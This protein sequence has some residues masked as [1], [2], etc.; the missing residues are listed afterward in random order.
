MGLIES[1]TT[2][3]FVAFFS[4]R[5][6]GGY[7]RSEAPSGLERLSQ[8]WH[9]IGMADSPAQPDDLD[10]RDIRDGLRERIRL[11]QSIVDDAQAKYE[12]EKA[13]R[14]IEHKKNIEGLKGTLTNY[15]NML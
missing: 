12:A 3:S 9:T 5:T 2:D 1:T 11:L 13:K 8:L 6:N 14:E 7:S 10:Y 15:K 4:R